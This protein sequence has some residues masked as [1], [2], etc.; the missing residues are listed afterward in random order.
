M[1]A[2]V[3]Q[4][5]LTCSL[6]PQA[7][8]AQGLRLCAKQAQGDQ[9][10]VAQL[11]V[12]VREAAFTE[13]ADLYAALLPDTEVRSKPE[14]ARMTIF[15]SIASSWLLSS[16]QPQATAHKHWG[17]DSITCRLNPWCIVCGCAL[18]LNLL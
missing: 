15:P 16:S 14:S 8:C 10:E 13:A 2:K 3:V 6:V 7:F 17:I 1:R 4:H 9:S 18:T 11:P 5:G 12:A